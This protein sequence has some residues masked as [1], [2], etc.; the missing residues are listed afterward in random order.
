MVP[1]SV[2]K[3]TVN[4]FIVGFLKVYTWKNWKDSHQNVIPP[5]WNYG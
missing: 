1:Y 3:I 5:S 4:I 2:K